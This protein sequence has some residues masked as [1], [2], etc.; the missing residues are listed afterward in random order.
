MGDDTTSLAEIVDMFSYSF[1]EIWLTGA[2]PD[3]GTA[4]GGISSTFESKSV[5]SNE[6]F[7]LLCKD[8]GDSNLLRFIRVGVGTETLL[9]EVLSAETISSERTVRH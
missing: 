8:G 4:S 7:C 9:G 5:I 1:P 3:V 6:K 2:V